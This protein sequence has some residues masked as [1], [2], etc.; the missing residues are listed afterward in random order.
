MNDP[1]NCGAICNQRTSVN[2]NLPTAT[3]E[4]DTAGL[5]EAIDTTPTVSAPANT[6]DAIAKPK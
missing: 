6:T 3:K 5:N 1:A 2:F 4:I